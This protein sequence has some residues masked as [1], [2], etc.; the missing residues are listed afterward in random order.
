MPSQLQEHLLGAIEQPGLEIV[1]RQLV[2]RAHALLGGEVGAIDQILVHADRALDFAAAA[3][4]AAQREVQLDGLRIDLDHLDERFDGL[5]GLL[6]DEKVETPEVGGGQRARL[7]Q[8]LLD[9]DARGEPAQ[10]EENRKTEQPPEL[11][12]HVLTRRA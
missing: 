4:Q 9:V 6:V 5:V 8:Q 10:A 11:E 12:F 2:Q 3:E 7:G 1:L